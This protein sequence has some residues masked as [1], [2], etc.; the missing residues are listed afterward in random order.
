LRIPPTQNVII[1]EMY[2]NNR[3][4]YKRLIS[5]VWPGGFNGYKN[6]KSLF[7]ATK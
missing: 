6:T 1:P 4:N 2:G 3:G 7:I 5:S